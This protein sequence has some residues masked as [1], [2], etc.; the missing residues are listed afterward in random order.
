MDAITIPIFP[1]PCVAFPGEMLSL[2]IFEERYLK[3]LSECLAFEERGEKASFGITCATPEHSYTI[4]CTVIIEQITKTYSDG[5][6]D[7]LTKGD[8]RYHTIEVTQRTPF[9]Q[10]KISFFDDIDVT[11]PHSELK[12]QAIRLHQALTEIAQGSEQEIVIS[13]NEM[14]SFV[15]AHSAG[16]DLEQRQALLEL[17]NESA[18]LEFLVEYYK[19]VL[20][21][22][23]NQQ[24]VKDRIAL[25]G[26][27]RTLNPSESL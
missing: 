6:V 18:R 15:L 11:P 1:I 5:R 17:T 19:W 12:E 26:H 9:P 20:P 8:K 22:L 23:K 2:H 14:T 4:G 10:A 13:T 25:N 7:I 27:L 16:L 24:Q 3:M 21:L